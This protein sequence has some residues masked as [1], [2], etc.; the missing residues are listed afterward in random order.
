MCR[1]ISLKSYRLKARISTSGGLS[2]CNSLYL[3]FTI[4]NSHLY[5]S[6]F[7]FASNNWFTYNWICYIAITYGFLTSALSALND[8]LTEMIFKPFFTCTLASPF[9]SIKYHRGRVKSSWED[10]QSTE[11]VFV[12]N[13]E[14][15][16]AKT[17]SG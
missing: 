7:S 6:I 9:L 2:K 3:Q 16:T 14:I 17:K 13:T 11:S 4:S 15:R 5:F 12:Q 10:T 8:P 1:N